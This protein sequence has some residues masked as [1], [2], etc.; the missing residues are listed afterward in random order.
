MR[1]FAGAIS[2]RSN[3]ESEHETSALGCLPGRVGAWISTASVSA[4]V[5]P[6][7]S[8]RKIASSA[9]LFDAGH[10]SRFATQSRRAVTTSGSLQP[11]GELEQRARPQ[12]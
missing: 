8:G 5:F 1:N 4:P 11:L 9:G 12:R 7:P 2:C 10:A 6:G 3:G